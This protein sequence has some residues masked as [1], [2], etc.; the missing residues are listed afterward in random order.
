[1]S[2]IEKALRLME[3]FSVN[4]PEIGL[5]EFRTLTGLDKGTLHRHLT[6]LKNCGFLEQNQTTRA[7]RLGPAVIRLS[8][9]R[10][11]TVPLIKSVEHYINK[12]TDQVHELTHA[13]LPE[14][15]GMSAIY[16]KD[17]GL[18]GTR[19]SFDE[20]EILPFHATSSGIAMLAFSS[21][22]LVKQVLAQQHERYTDKTSTDTDEIVALIE[23]AKLHGIA[24]ANQTYEAEV[25]SFAVPFFAHPGGAM[26]T[27]AI[28]APASRMNSTLKK[29][30]IDQLIVAST[31]LSN[32][33]GGQIPSHIA[34][35]WAKRLET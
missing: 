31:E 33:L 6:S 26:G 16:A 15:K 24:S 14:S 35:T 12:I 29:K 13:A 5:T 9:V 28:A 21:E 19:V 34:D 3:H 30:C 23:I 32:N 22:K 2:T 11:K 10:E 4:R 7:Y 20:A 25:V 8:A 27:L 17:A 1:M 18:H